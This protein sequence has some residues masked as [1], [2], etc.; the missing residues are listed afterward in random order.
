MELTDRHIEAI[1][2]FIVTSQQ[3]ASW[4]KYFGTGNK[5]ADKVAA[6]KFFKRP[7][8]K[9]MVKIL[10]DSRE[11]AIVEATKKTYEKLYAE[12]IASELE[13]D[14]FHTKVLRGE[15]EMEEVFAVREKRFNAMAKTME[16]QVVFKRVKRTPSIKE[17]QISSDLLYK[18]KG[19]YKGVTK[20]QI[21]QDD[22][23]AAAIAKD[24]QGQIE[25]CVILSD[26]TKLPIV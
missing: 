24:G 2:E 22:Q 1:K 5:D 7:E 17:K 18:R 10:R 23:K 11:K 19:S 26:G 21:E 14:I 6:S 20:V 12:Q 16:E 25:R 4:E 15:A 3:G 9:R 13:L 8:A